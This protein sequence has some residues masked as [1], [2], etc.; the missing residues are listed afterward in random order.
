M[1][2][3]L[4][5]DSFDRANGPVGTAD[6]GQTYISGTLGTWS[7]SGSQLLSTASVVGERIGGNLGAGVYDYYLSFTANKGTN[8]FPYTYVRWTDENN[9]LL[10]YRYYGVVYYFAVVGGIQTYN[11]ASNLIQNDP[12]EWS[13]QVISSS[14]NGYTNGNLM[15]SYNITSSILMSG[16][17]FYL[18]NYSLTSTSFDNLIVLTAPIARPAT[19]IVS[20]SGSPVGDGTLA[21][22]QQ[23]QRVTQWPGI[24]A[25]GDHV[26]LRSGDYGNTADR[27]RVNWST[28]GTASNPVIFERYAPDF[29]NLPPNRWPHIHHQT[30]LPNGG[31]GF[32]DIYDID[33]AG[34][35]PTRYTGY[36]VGDSNNTTISF[37]NQQDGVRVINCLFHDWAS[38]GMDLWTGSG[39]G[40]WGC[41]NWYNGW[42]DQVNGLCSGHGTY[43]QNFG[44]GFHNFIDNIYWCNY[45]YGIQAYGSSAARVKYYNIKGNTIFYSG[46]PGT[47]TTGGQSRGSLLAGGF[48]ST[49]VLD[50]FVDSN[51]FYEV[52]EGEMQMGYTGIFSNTSSFISNNYC[53]SEGAGIFSV[54]YFVSASVYG[55]TFIQTAR[56][57]INYYGWQYPGIFSVGWNQWQYYPTGSWNNNTYIMPSTASFMSELTD[58]GS[59]YCSGSPTSQLQ[60]W[61]NRHGQDVNSTLRVGTPSGVYISVRPSQIRPTAINVPRA[62][63]T[64]VNWTRET[65]VYADVSNCL[66]PGDIWQ[67]WHVF[68]W[69]QGNPYDQTGIYDGKPIPIILTKVNPPP[70]VA[71]GI[72]QSFYDPIYGPPPGRPGVYV[73]VKTGVASRPPQLS[74]L[75]NP[76]G[77][78]YI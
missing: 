45:N 29:V 44:P 1:P 19:W 67:L 58:T 16:S 62:H 50:V 77:I 64:V 73:L 41:Y 9:Y 63:I 46:I 59:Y 3:R 56:P 4:W 49:T 21:A 42:V 13:F 47:S 75:H 15:F 74:A 39:S 43:T 72:S 35:D 5:G 37:S 65:I 27:Y 14:F 31:I 11:S 20:P 53:V 25:A 40:Y 68:N 57:Y 30:N 17:Q 38:D 2:T 7:I 24:V 34:N 26:Q 69:V 33:F 76:Q 70:I 51:V 22:P 61:N 48:G 71:N 54:S 10:A 36:D 28:Y 60:Q 18:G 66:S 52:V 23:W 32:L 55:N 12:T 6:S 78:W 8:G